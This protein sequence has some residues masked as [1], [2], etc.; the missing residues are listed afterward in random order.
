MIVLLFSRGI[1]ATG[2]G[3]RA[4][5]AISVNRV[6][7]NRGNP[8]SNGAALANRALT[9]HAIPAKAAA[10][11]GVS[12]HANHAVTTGIS[13]R[14]AISRT[15]IVPRNPKRRKKPAVSWVG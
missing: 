11:S 3:S 6:R 5:R 15:T 14:A 2:M 1:A 12:S 4:I 8:A 9:S 13:S 10:N 7:S